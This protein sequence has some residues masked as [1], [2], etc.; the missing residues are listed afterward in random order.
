MCEL[1]KQLESEKKSLEVKEL[2]SSCRYHKRSPER[3]ICGDIFKGF[4]CLELFHAVYPKV[5]ALMYGAR[6]SEEELIM[7][8]PHYKDTVTV[9]LYS[10]SIKSI[11]RRFLNKVK[12]LL[13]FL[14]PMD[15]VNQ[16]VYV[17]ILSVD[18]RC[19]AGYKKGDA[20][21]IHHTGTICPQALYSAFPGVLLSK[22]DNICQCPSD[23]NR[24]VFQKSKL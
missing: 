18:G 5:L 22:E 14:Y 11:I 24:V 16:V 3:F 23:V 4:K 17:E 6:F 9:R 19:F 2:S 7:R 1:L 21:E 15:V 20:F 8:C 13:H 10:K 12:Q